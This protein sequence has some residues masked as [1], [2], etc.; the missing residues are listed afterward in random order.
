MNTHILHPHYP[1][2]TRSYPRSHRCLQ[3]GRMYGDL[4]TRCMLH[5]DILQ[6]NIHTVPARHT[7]A[8]RSRS[9]THK[10]MHTRIAY[11]HIP[12]PQLR[13]VA[14]FCLSLPLLLSPTPFSLSLFGNSNTPAVKRPGSPPP[15]TEE[16]V[17]G[18]LYLLFFVPL[19]I[20]PFAFWAGGAKGEMAN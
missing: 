4:Q 14:R 2:C 16:N 18:G 9:C 1:Y 3:D 15:Q 19:L 8:R 6:E 13:F 11:S 20:P 7:D 10:R 5:L 12:D 17:P